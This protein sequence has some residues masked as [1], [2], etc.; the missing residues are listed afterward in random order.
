MELCRGFN[1]FFVGFFFKRHEDAL[2][3]PRRLLTDTITITVRSHFWPGGG[4]R[5]GGLPFQSVGI[6]PAADL[7]MSHLLI[8]ERSFHYSHALG[9]CDASSMCDH[10][11]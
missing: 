7:L 10:H 4:S 6:H 1:C 5:V 3:G 8:Q 11:Y 2:K 9:K